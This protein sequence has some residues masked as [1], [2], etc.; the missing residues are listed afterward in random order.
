MD[1]HTLIQAQMELMGND[2]PVASCGLHGATRR[3]V[4][5]Q[6][7]EYL[8]KSLANTERDEPSRYG[9]RINV[10]II[11]KGSQDSNH[12]KSQHKTLRKS[13]RRVLLFMT[14]RANGHPHPYF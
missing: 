6:A 12:S 13:T 5:E 11:K 3:D 10:E 14:W 1:L 2:Q 8:Q 7:I 9:Y 4:I